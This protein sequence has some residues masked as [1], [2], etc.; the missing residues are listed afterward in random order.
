MRKN[1]EAISLKS[2]TEVKK[3]LNAHPRF[4]LHFTPT[5]ASWLNAVESWFARLERQSIH[6]GVFSSVKELGDEIHRFIKVH[7]AQSAKPFKW[8]KS[9]KSIID[10]VERAKKP[11]TVTINQTGH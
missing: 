3:W 1:D 7:N 11:L 8:T 5:S 10:T 2:S 9:A 4:I 6:R